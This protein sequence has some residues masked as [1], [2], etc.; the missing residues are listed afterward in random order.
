[1]GK[2]KASKQQLLNL[3]KK[4]QRAAARAQLA[5]ALDASHASPSALGGAADGEDRKKDPSALVEAGTCGEKNPLALGA[6]EDG[7]DEDDPRLSLFEAGMS[8]EDPSVRVAL[9][10]GG[11]PSMPIESETA[12]GKDPSALVAAASGAASQ[13]QYDVSLNDDVCEIC[14]LGGKLLCCDHCSLAFHLQ[15]IVPELDKLPSGVWYCTLC[16]RN[17]LV[18]APREDVRQA[19]TDW[20]QMK[21]LRNKH[22]EAKK[23][24]SLDASIITPNPKRQKADHS[25]NPKRQKADHSFVQSF[26][27]MSEA[28]QRSCMGALF[29][30]ERIA[31]ILP[32]PP[33]ASGRSS[34]D[35]ANEAERQSLSDPNAYRP[36]ES[37]AFHWY[38]P[39]LH[40]GRHRSTI[41]ENMH[42]R[43]DIKSAAKQAC[44]HV[45]RKMVK[46]IMDLKLTSEQRRLALWT[47]FSLPDLKPIIQSLGLDSESSRMGLFIANN[48]SRFLHRARVTGKLRGRVPDA[49]RAAAQAVI[50]SCIQTPEK[51]QD[52]N[53]KQTNR[54]AGVPGGSLLKLFGI[55]EGSNYL[56][57]KAAESRLAIKEDSDAAWDFLGTRKS[58]T[59]VPPA[60]I[61]QLR[62]EWLPTC[63]YIKDV[64]SKRETVQMRDV[65]RKI[66]R[67]DD[68]NP[69]IVQTV[70]CSHK[71]REVH[72]LMVKDDSEG[73]FAGATDNEG[74]A[75]IS[76]TKLRDVWPNWIK[77]MTPRYKEMCGCDQCGVPTSLQDSLTRRRH[78]IL[79][80]LRRRVKDMR[81]GRQK[82]RA[83]SHLECYKNEILADGV[84]KV[85]KP[86]QAAEAMSCPSI[87][88]NGVTLPRF[89]CAIGDCK[90]CQDRYEPSQFESTC[91]DIIKYEVY[92]PVHHCN[93]HGDAFLTTVVEVGK[94][95]RKCTK[96]MEMTEEEIQEKRKTK[97][98]AKIVSKKYRTAKRDPLK[99]FVKKGGTYQKGIKA[100]RAHRWHRKFLGHGVALKAYR[101]YVH[102]NPRTHIVTNRD[103]ANR[104]Q[105][106][107]DLEYQSE[108][109]A[110]EQSLSMEGCAADYYNIIT[111]QHQTIFFSHLSID[112]RQD[113]GTVASN[114]RTM[115]INIL[116]ERKEM[117]VGVL[118]VLVCICDGCAVQYRSWNVCYELCS[119]AKEF[120]IVID[121]IIQAPGHGKC[122]VD[123]Q[124]GVDKS[125][126]DMFFDCLVSTP[127]GR[128][129][130]VKTVLTHDRDEDGNVVRLSEVAL[131]IL[132]D[133]DRTHGA[134]GGKN[135]AK[136][137]KILERRYFERLVGAAG[138]EGVRYMCRVV[139]KI[140][141]CYHIRADPELPA[142]Q[143]AMR[144]F[145]CCCAGCLAKLDKP[146]ETR[147]AGA[148]RTCTYWEFF[149]K[150]DGQSGYNDWTV[151]TL[152]PR[153]N[154]Y[155][156]EDVLE[157]KAATVRGIGRMM[158]DQ[159]IVGGYGAYPVKD[160]RY[161][162]YLVQWTEEPRE[163]EGDT[164]ITLGGESFP[165][166]KGDL[167][168]KGKW[169]D[170]V[171]GSLRW[172][173]QTPQECIV[174]MQTVVDADIDLAPIG[175]ENELPSNM[176]RE[177]KQ[178]ARE[179]KALRVS[180]EDHEL[181]VEEA[182]RRDAFDHE[183]EVE[184]V[185]S[186]S[187]EGES[188]EESCD[189]FDA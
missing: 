13:A 39:N 12:G 21:N 65:N 82:E 149:K 180:D 113:A 84:L 32:H 44:D 107:A 52:G 181:L 117:K 19:K 133:P 29:R 47:A 43:F 160:D 85:Q 27:R 179:K 73:G 36:L 66:I 81:D 125:L 126:L 135:R 5:A 87:T 172:W 116:Y 163:V 11:D 4:Q 121:R 122:V 59:K 178:F 49:Q 51:D 112:P 140:K 64:P 80:N 145:P 108:H 58:W 35:A 167:V 56:I 158:A 3:K 18:G 89:C 120:N 40:G 45:A 98:S 141:M 173:Y 118:K 62:V 22:R 184:V 162:Y 10:A 55:P 115:L 71:P 57:K 129:N 77:S 123:S 48:V 136:N 54:A 153:T 102:K 147:Y 119:L 70:V 106:N 132:N 144:R 60:M 164:T 88:I 83:S 166:R 68:N 161:D 17:H 24:T 189:E 186:N 128:V 93:W 50:S 14:D 137:R 8:G 79:A 94:E 187:E 131:D 99:E 67:D 90:E 6:A 30:D 174:R 175:P 183:E 110:K 157:R 7:E 143:V 78:K 69:I 151:V 127:E 28:E 124:N 31:N 101:E 25:F 15:C 168:C 26:F 96:C 63:K 95:K 171:P 61:E 53:I 150:E 177:R 152:E 114:I 86:S 165:V 97:K 74:K 72:N 75:L 38:T 42:D 41:P 23:R 2:K 142:L 111:G 159:V 76:E 139:G 155:V 91:D 185:D 92:S 37:N 100:Y 170:T 104:Y 176:R 103:H 1:M 154:G 109:Y 46:H 188:D 105:K 20:E 182:L 16:I 34:N 169:L 156:E 130:D 134:K 9:T 148:S 138:G 33:I 146:I